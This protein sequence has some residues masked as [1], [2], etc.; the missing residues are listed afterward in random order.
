MNTER[1]KPYLCFFVFVCL[2]LLCVSCVSCLFLSL[3]LLVGVCVNC[4]CLLLVSVSPCLSP[5][6]S[7]LCLVLS[8]CLLLLSGL[9]VALSVSPC[10]LSI[11]PFSLP[12][13]LSHPPRD[14]CLKVSRKLKQ[15]S[16]NTFFFISPWYILF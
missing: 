10:Y 4:L 7:S 6:L 15:G 5:S 16:S 11:P 14:V 8:Q 1:K 12:A 13:C 2:F 9:C 3:G